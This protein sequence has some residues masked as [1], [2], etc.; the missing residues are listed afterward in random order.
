V[1]KSPH[2]LFGEALVAHSKGE[3]HPFVLIDPDGNEYEYSLAD[4][5]RSFSKLNH[6][7]QAAINQARG[8]IL[9][10]GCG[11][12][13]MLVALSC[14][15][16]VQGLDISPHCVDLTKER[17]FSCT[18]GDIYSF[19]PAKLFDTITLFGN[20]IGMAGTEANLPD[21]LIKLVSLLTPNGRVLAVTRNYD[22]D[23]FYEQRLTPK[24]NG[25]TGETFSWLLFD[26]RSL[27]ET[28][29]KSGIKLNTV[30]R[31]WKYRLL[32]FSSAR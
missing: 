25:R 15:G 23:G 4:R 16:N 26:E 31:S 10:V 20:G 24:W 28:C 6:T 14:K 18:H 2:D 30:S 8:H 17:G 21:F 1:D 32:E 5:F 27:A 19:Q 13:N 29:V 11:T 12:G 3:R 9:D 22:V 7:E